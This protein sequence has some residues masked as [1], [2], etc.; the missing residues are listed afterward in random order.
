MSPCMT[1]NQKTLDPDAVNIKDLSIVKQLLFVA[2][3]HLRQLTEMINNPAACF[4]DQIPVLDLADVQLRIPEQPG[5][6][7]STAPTWSVS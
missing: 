1:G 7:A 3:R 5:L 2:D 4:S 6:S